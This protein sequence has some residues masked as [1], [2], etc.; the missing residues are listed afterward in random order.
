[1]TGLAEHRRGLGQRERRGLVEDAL[2][3][4]QVR[5]QA[6]TELVGEGQHVAPPRRPVEQQVRVLARHG[7]GAERAGPL[8]GPHR[9]VDPPLV[10]EAPGDVGQL[11]RERAVGVEHQRAGRRPAELSSTSATDA[12]RS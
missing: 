3:A 11:G 2:P 7:V 10:E 5:V 8:A 1:M 9:R 4:G 12:M 6:V